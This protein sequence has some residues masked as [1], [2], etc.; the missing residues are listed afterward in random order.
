LYRRNYFFNYQYASNFNI[1]KSIKFNYNI[2]TSNIVRN[3]LDEN[4]RPIDEYNIWHDFWNAGEPNQHNQQFVINYEVPL[5]K[6][7]FLNFMKS[8]YTYTGNYSWQRSSDA[9]S[10]V[11]IGG[12][13][14]DL[15]NIIQ[16]ANIHKL[17][18]T[19]SMDMF[20]K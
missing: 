4:N 12:V 14:Y 6:L 1:T 5:N 8:T 19:L 11:E 10:E 16:N 13:V 18:T 9:L 20:Y 2:S 15:G 17:N 3:Y 7:P